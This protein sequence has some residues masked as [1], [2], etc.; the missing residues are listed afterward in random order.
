MREGIERSHFGEACAARARARH[1]QSSG[2]GRP[3]LVYKIDWDEEER[4]YKWPEVVTQIDGML[5]LAAP[6]VAFDAWCRI[7]PSQRAEQLGPTLV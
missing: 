2:R 3:E 7:A 4:P 6:A 1:W 5:A